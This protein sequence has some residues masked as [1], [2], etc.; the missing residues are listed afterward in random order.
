MPVEPL[1]SLVIWILYSMASAAYMPGLT[2]NMEFNNDKFGCLRCWPHQE[3]LDLISNHYY[4]DQGGL[5]I[6]EPSQV[7]DLVILFSTELSFK[8]YNEK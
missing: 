8:I 3:K 1:I 7:K 5:D 6:K 2:V 4:K